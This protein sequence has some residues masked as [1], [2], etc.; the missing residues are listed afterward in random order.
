MTTSLD[1]NTLSTRANPTIEEI[2]RYYLDIRRPEI[3]ETTYQS[4]CAQ[5][6][7]YIIGPLPTGSKRDRWVF[8]HTGCCPEG[9]HLV[10][11]LGQLPLADLTTARIRHW[12]RALAEL[13]SSST[14]RVAKKH[15]RAALA[16]AAED[17][18]LRIPMMPRHRG[19]GHTRPRKSIL[20]PTQI[21]QLLN[22]ALA[23]E[24]MGIYYAFPFLTGVRP[25][26]Q[27]ALRWDD[28]DF[29]A[30]L[31]RI[32]RMQ[33]SDGKIC[34]LTKTPASTR[35][36]PISPLLRTMLRKWQA[37]CPRLNVETWLVFP[38][39]GGYRCSIH[40][41]RGAALSYV[42]FRTTYWQPVFATLGLPY[43][44]PHSARHAFISTLQARGVEVGLVAQ[45][46]GH[47]DPAVT[48]SVYTHAV[49]DGSGAVA[50]LETAY[51]QL[52][53]LKQP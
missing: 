42:N 52:D 36:I 45:L 49:R 3:K 10:E 18:D 20:N 48:L 29:G 21:G 19:R 15:L 7:P 26:E 12:H 13:V 41:K 33:Q 46:A 1:N 34:A 51:T 32:R 22:A 11:M 37:I 23:D 17:F 44:T 31:I 5:V 47:A 25:S 38:S 40:K 30:D 8:S 53:A 6:V 4:Y 35:Q 28:I 50:A 2:V 39:L 14:A 27:L 9:Q 43:V 16:L 24:T